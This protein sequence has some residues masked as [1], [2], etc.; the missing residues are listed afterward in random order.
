MTETI[1]VGWD[2]SEPA[3]GALRWAVSR[4]IALDERV[5]LARV[6][7]NTISTAEYFVSDSAAAAARIALMDDVAEARDQYPEA[8]IT[9]EL[10]L[11]DPS[12]A[13]ARLSTAEDI[14]VVGTHRRAGQLA[15]FAWSVGAR[16]SRQSGGPVAIIPEDNVRPRR[17]IVVGVDWSAASRAAVLFAAREAN[18]SGDELLAIHAWHEASGDGGHHEDDDDEPAAELQR[19]REET[20]EAALRPV[21]A[22]YPALKLRR[23]AVRG[24]A[25]D[26]LAEACLD[27][28]MLVVGNHGASGIVDRMLGS[29]CASLILS[30]SGPMVVVRAPESG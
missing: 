23:R 1:I 16:L 11:G 28:T 24:R 17:G 21:V 2:R 3:R 12:E 9:S 4:G 7:D 14:V 8:S 26:V 19:M 25:E 29:V 20:L 13:L 5:T 22:R 6:V 18:R 10:I 30:L 15:R 27:S